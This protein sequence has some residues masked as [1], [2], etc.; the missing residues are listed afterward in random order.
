MKRKINILYNESHSNLHTQTLNPQGGPSR[1]SQSFRDYFLAKKEVNLI[2]VLFS[3]EDG[4][5][6]PYIRTTSQDSKE[7]FELVYDRNSINSFYK[8]NITKP[9]LIKHL[10][11]WIAQLEEFFEGK[12][13]DLIFLNGFGL[14]NWMLLH[15]A[16][17][18]NIPVAIQHAGVWKKEVQRVKEGFS[19]AIRKIFYDLERDTAR[20]CAMHIFLNTYSKKVFMDAYKKALKKKIPSIVIPLPISVAAIPKN[21]KNKSGKVSIGIV[22]RWDSIKNHTAILRL[23]SSKFLPS[24]W[25]VNAV[26]RIP[27][28][29]DF[30]KKYTEVVTIHKPMSPELL[31]NFY[32]STDIT[33][34]LSHFD[35]SPTVIAESFAAGTPVI[36]SDKVGWQDEYKAC[37]LEDHIV[38]TRIGGKT[39]VAVIKKV[40]SQ[41]SK[42]TTKYKKFSKYVART[43]SPKKVFD[44][45]FSLFQSITNK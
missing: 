4:N 16:H 23:A 40:L 1:F 35:V 10:A 11:P 31:T 38:P 33:I 44:D 21:K 12:K 28:P 7:F 3:H 25:S 26:T 41:Q 13:P 17:K 8:K 43:H 27:R 32:A 29:S 39:L 18:K 15:V 24:H 36:I 37:G 9:H 30:S 45:Y 20:W 5:K 2:P 22:A 42:N 34:L 14:T 19:P 6:K